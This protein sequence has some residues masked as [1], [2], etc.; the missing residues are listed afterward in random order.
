VV[1]GAQ[2]L[3]LRRIPWLTA[4]LVVVSL[5][6]YPSDLLR[7]ALL[8]DRT[9]ILHGELWR[10]WTGHLVH[11]TPA[12]LVADLAIVALAGGLLELRLR[13][14]YPWLL[15]GTPLIVSLAFLFGLPEMAVYGGLSALGSAMIAA[16]A[17][18][19]LTGAKGVGPVA[20]AVL[21]LLC[22]KIAW[23]TAAATSLLLQW[24]D[25]P[26][27]PV[28]LAHAAGA[29]AGLGAVLLH[30][31]IPALPRKAKQNPARVPSGGPPLSKDSC[32][33]AAKNGDDGG[34]RICDP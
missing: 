5:L 3:I 20:L 28:P 27:V 15:A 1:A 14:G 11:F 19:G 7:G 10:L 17:A 30:R 22:G 33:E 23:E 25:Q 34:R 24:S 32:Q 29:L 2:G 4:L 18:L 16:L 31:D 21:L 6:I 12:H 9:A 26:F 13:K 8:Y